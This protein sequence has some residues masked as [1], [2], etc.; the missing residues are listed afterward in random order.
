MSKGKGRTPTKE[1]D[2]KREVRTPKYRMRVEKD[3][4]KYDRYQNQHVID[5]EFDDYE[6]DEYEEE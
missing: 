2:V 4:T 5:E 6:D 3:R 1:S